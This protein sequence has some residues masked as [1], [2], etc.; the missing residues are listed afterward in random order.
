MRRPVTRGSRPT[1]PRVIWEWKVPAIHTVDA[2]DRESGVKV[3]PVRSRWPCGR[4]TASSLAEVTSW[5]PRTVHASS[6]PSSPVST[7]VRP[8]SRPASSSSV[9]SSGREAKAGLDDQ[10]VAGVAR[11]PWAP[12]P[13]GAHGVGVAA[14]ATS[15]Q[16]AS[17][18]DVAAGWS[19]EG[20]APEAGAV[21][22]SRCDL[23]RGVL[24]RDER[25]LV[26]EALARQ[27]DGVE[28]GPVDAVARCGD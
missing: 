24:Q 26:L 17:A 22:V 4:R 6:V 2:S 3:S 7:S 10:R 8:S 12:S 19:L 18:S 5:P 23:D 27:V 9:R 14:T 20:D 16:R 28:P 21:G 13:A 11:R 1:W 15:A 25:V